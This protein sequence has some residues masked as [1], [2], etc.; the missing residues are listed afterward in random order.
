VIERLDFRTKKADLENVDP[1]QA[2]MLSY[3]A[4]NQVASGIKSAAFRAGV[5]VIEV[6]PA[7]TSV[8]GA[9]NYAQKHGI[10]VHQGAA[11]AIARRGLGL[12][13]R[14]TVRT[15]CAPVRNGGHVTF[16]LPVR[17]RSKHVWSYWSNVRTCLK[18]AHAAHFR[19]GDHKRPP[20]P[21]SPAK[22]GEGATGNSSAESRHANRSQ[23]CSESV[24]DD[25]PW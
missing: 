18:A 25:V 23:H 5:E 12:S 11:F 9:S 19:C 7:Y 3:F 15:G 2:R 24:L 13:E 22:P 8:I 10:A 17:N 6:N 14:P 21:L 20:P 1:R 4:C 16:D